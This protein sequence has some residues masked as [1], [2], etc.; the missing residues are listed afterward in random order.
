MDDLFKGQV[1]FD[2]RKTGQKDRLLQILL[3][4]LCSKISYI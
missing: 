1:D 2:L 3:K 4:T